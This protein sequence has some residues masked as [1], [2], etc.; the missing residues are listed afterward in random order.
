MHVKRNLVTSV[1]WPETPE[2]HSCNHAQYWRK[3]LLLKDGVMYCYIYAGTQ[4]LY[5][6][7][8]GVKQYR[9]SSMQG[10]TSD[11]NTE[12]LLYKVSRL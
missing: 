8:S 6:L 11:V 9:L 12:S 7:L 1:R 3:D 2:S 5:H 10:F 4:T